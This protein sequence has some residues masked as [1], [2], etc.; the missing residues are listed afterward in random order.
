M[1]PNSDDGISELSRTEDEL[2]CLCTWPGHMIRMS[3]RE[4]QSV[5]YKCET[6][7]ISQGGVREDQREREQKYGKR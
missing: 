5:A 4:K 2:S 1:F 6:F 3:W 7:R